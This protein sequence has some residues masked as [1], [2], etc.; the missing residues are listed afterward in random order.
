MRAT[1][2]LAFL[3]LALTLTACIADPAA[4]ASA[5]PE[6]IPVTDLSSASPASPAAPSAAP[7][8]QVPATAQPTAAPT[9][10]PT[11]APTATEPITT[12]PAPSTSGPAAA[13]CR[14]GWVRPAAGSTEYEAALA[15]LSAQMGVE[16]PWMVDD[17][18]YFTG[19]EVPFSE[20]AYEPV[21]RWYV[22]AAL[23]NDPA[24]RARWILERRTDLIQGISAVAAYESTGF[25]SPDW[26]A[27][28]GE[29]EPVSYLGLPGQWAGI[30]YDFVTGE[31]DSGNPGLPDQVLGCISGA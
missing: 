26:T 19:P 5:P 28:V 31:G 24:F 13:D 20:P 14:D 9:P 21:E 22:K 23:A 25:E 3:M 6:T 2:W 18:R 8:T 12:E 4:V 10:A 27:F 7:R 17:M 11:P 15:L 1:A 30:P 16:G 29:G